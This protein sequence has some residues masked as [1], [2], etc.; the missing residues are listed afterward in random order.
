MVV[1]PDNKRECAFS[2]FKNKP[3]EDQ[4][5]YHQMSVL[6]TTLSFYERHIS[7]PL[8]NLFVNPGH[9]SNWSC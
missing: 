7:T 1:I 2:I 3:H 9:R 8:S 6:N 5:S 4:P